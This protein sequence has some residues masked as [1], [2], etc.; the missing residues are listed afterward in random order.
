MFKCSASTCP[1]DLVEFYLSRAELQYARGLVDEA[2]ESANTA[3]SLNP[4]AEKQT[5][6]KLFVA[7][8]KSSLGE[9]L[10]SNKIYHEL[11]SEFIYLP[12]V[13]LGIL[14]NN[15][16]LSKNDKSEKNLSL[17]QIFLG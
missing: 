16:H 17:M 3:L 6:L 4:N 9:F 8:A 13:I 12:P 7:R 10:E 2:I 5:A 15:L 14:H 1:V 11:I